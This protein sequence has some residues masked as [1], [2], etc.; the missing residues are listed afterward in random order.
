MFGQAATKIKF[1]Y[2]FSLQGQNRGTTRFNNPQDYN[3]FG[4]GQ[5]TLENE[6]D[7]SLRSNRVREIDSVAN[8]NAHRKSRFRSKEELEVNDKPIDEQILPR[9]HKFS[10]I[11]DVSPIIR[12]RPIRVGRRRITTPISST[13]TTVTPSTKT[14]TI[15]STVTTVIPS[16][17]TT[18]IPSTVTTP[19]PSTDI[20]MVIPKKVK[21]DL[22]ET[23]KSGNGQPLI[24]S[25]TRIRDQADTFNKTIAKP[26][27][28]LRIRN[29]THNVPVVNI[30]RFSPSNATTTKTPSTT[31]VTS[32]PNRISYRKSNRYQA[33]ASGKVEAISTETTTQRFIRRPIIR[34]TEKTPAD[35]EGSTTQLPPPLS[36]GTVRSS[37]QIY[38]KEKPDELEDLEDENYPEH[39]K[40]LLK[41]NYHSNSSTAVP[42]TNKVTKFKN[43]K[44][45]RVVPYRGYKQSSSSP[46]TP[47][48]T[49][50]NFIEPSAKSNLPRSNRNDKRSRNVSIESNDVYVNDLDSTKANFNLV[51]ETNY[52]E[53]TT[54]SGR[55][56]SQIQHKEKS[57]AVTT[58]KPPISKLLVRNKLFKNRGHTVDTDL[59]IP[60]SPANQPPVSIR[61]V[62]CLLIFFYKFP[63]IQF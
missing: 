27:N 12:K 50:S 47:S 8:N 41:A 46:S 59:N 34:S 56:S 43:F 16:T 53:G 23:D 28:V 24:T 45:R 44:S 22:R 32:S 61:E 13:V 15:P 36:R 62:S 55:F 39:F 40:L 49:Q 11:D 6:S 1:F 4:I 7:K 29:L 63:L 10:P 57:Y 35:L 30:R 51:K 18:T 33:N 19:I 52:P 2:Y 48:T 20:P 58:F 14:T 21:N 5:E 31:N 9:N 60:Q 26:E 25:S 37:K 3:S 38:A 54:A 42:D 17:V